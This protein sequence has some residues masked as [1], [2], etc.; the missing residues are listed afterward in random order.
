MDWK[1]VVGGILM[2]VSFI[3]IGNWYFYWISSQQIEKIFEEQILCSKYEPIAIFDDQ[4]I[5][6]KITCVLLRREPI[7]LRY[8]YI[9]LEKGKIYDAEPVLIKVKD[10]NITVFARVH[11]KWTE[12]KC[13]Y[14]GTKPIIHFAPIFHTPYCQPNDIIFLYLKFAIFVVIPLV[15]GIILLLL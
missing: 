7:L 5:P 13:N 11:Y 4:E 1:K 12:L 14:I 6:T 3:N 9:W 10:S 8:E 15:I 2:I